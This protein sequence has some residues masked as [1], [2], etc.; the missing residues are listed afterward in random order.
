M[1]SLV[2]LGRDMGPR[3]NQTERRNG[4]ELGYDRRGD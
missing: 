4:S 2:Q 1:C 3:I